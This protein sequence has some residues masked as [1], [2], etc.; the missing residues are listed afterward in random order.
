MHSFDVTACAH[1]TGRAME[2]L[3]ASGIRGNWATL[4]LPINDDESIDFGRLRAEI[5]TLIAAGVDGI[6]SN[7]TTGEFHNQ[8]QHEF[9]RVS[10]LLAQLCESAG[11][12]F[13]LG[14]GH[15]SPALTLERVRFAATLCP[16]AIQVILPDWFPVT[17]AEAIAFLTRVTAVTDPIGVVLY[18]PPHAKRVLAPETFGALQAAVPLLVGVKVADGDEAWYV[19]MRK[20]ASKLSVFVPGHHLATG[21]SQGAAGSYSNVA[22]LSPRGAQ[23]W[24]DLMHTDMPAALALEQRLRQ[25]MSAHIEPLI[26]RERFANPAVDKLLAA[27]GAWAPV[28]TRMRWPYRSVPPA[29]AEELRPIAQALLPEFLT[30]P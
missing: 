14:A 26:S 10:T 23:H 9:E 18:N 2:P 7:G 3:C 15:M 24:T 4:I 8:T 21:L 1:Y 5:E 16:S 6:Y 11:M 28:G 29:Q 13:Q 30:A 19:Q 27:I 22:C 25:F 17:D 20:H 12:P